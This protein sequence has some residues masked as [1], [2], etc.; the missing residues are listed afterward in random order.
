[1]QFEAAFP[2]VQERAA[3]FARQMGPHAAKRLQADLGIEEW[4]AE[5]V[6]SRRASLPVIMRMIAAYG[7]RCASFVLE[8]VCGRVDKLELAHRIEAT[9][10]LAREAL[11]EA[12]ELRQEIAAQVGG[13]AQSPRGERDLVRTVVPADGAQADAVAVHARA[14]YRRY[15]R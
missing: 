14:T 5:R 9:E 11:N 13:L 3:H 2:V 12:H 15:P 8:P 7:W 4:T 10:R 1:M 6:L